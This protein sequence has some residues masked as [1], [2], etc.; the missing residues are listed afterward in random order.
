MKNHQAKFVRRGMARVTLNGV[1]LLLAAAFVT[2][3][4]VSSTAS[5]QS[6]YSDA[7]MVDDET[8]YADEYSTPQSDLVGV[9]VSEADYNS[10]V[11]STSTYTT[12]TA[13]NGATISNYSSGYNYARSDAFSLRL[14]LD[15]SVEG[16]YN[17]SSE[18]TYYQE[19]YGDCS[20]PRDQQ[21]DPQIQRPAEPCY[22]SGAG[23]LQPLFQRAAFAVAGAARAPAPQFYYYWVSRSYFAFIVRIKYTGYQFA[24]EGYAGCNSRNG[25]PFGYSAFCPL[26][27]ICQ[28]AAKCAPGAAPGMQGI[29]L[30]LNAYFFQTCNVKYYYVPMRPMCS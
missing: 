5:A 16:E 18:H 28:K 15:A 17:V 8:V 25:G 3:A 9:G 13:P 26:N 27:N 21:M 2:L 6:E 10:G 7:W 24:G 1:R 14:S 19:N 20:Q 23:G 30:L 29:G 11:Y 4:G 12:L 22:M